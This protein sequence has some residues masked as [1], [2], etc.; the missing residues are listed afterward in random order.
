MILPQSIH[1]AVVVNSGLEVKFVFACFQV[2][3]RAKECIA[4]ASGDQQPDWFP[5]LQHHRFAS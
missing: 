1:V 4:M 2:R 3:L 5:C